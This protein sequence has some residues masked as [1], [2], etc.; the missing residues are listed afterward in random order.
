MDFQVS[1]IGSVISKIQ[2]RRNHA[3]ALARSSGPA[4]FLRELF[5]NPAATGAPCPSSRQ[6]GVKMAAGVSETGCG[7]V[8]ELGAGTGVVTQALLDR[9]IQPE[10]LLVVER[11]PA[12]FDHLRQRFPHLRIVLADAAHLQKLVPYG[13]A[14]DTLVSSIPLR[15]LPFEQSEAIVAHWRNLVPRGTPLIQFTYAL[16][17]PLRHLSS[18]FPVRD[19]TIA[20]LNFPPARVVSFEL[21]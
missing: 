12:L 2:A 4:L 14:I 6:L 18:R 1:L 17:G 9:G 16:R 10:R 15:S 11:S 13:T 5:L 19:T 8:I 21:R 3:F 7:L 20:W